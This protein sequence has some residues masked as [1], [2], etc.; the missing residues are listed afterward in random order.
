MKEY[1]K[2]FMKDQGL[3]DLLNLLPVLVIINNNIILG[4]W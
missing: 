3:I 1:Y 4:F 2:D